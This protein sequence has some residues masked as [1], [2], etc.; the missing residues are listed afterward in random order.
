MNYRQLGR[1]DLRVSELC[2]GT[3]TFGQP[4][5]GCDAQT[6]TDIVDR[7]VDAGGNFFDTAD[8]Y[9]QGEAERMLGRALRGR[10]S[11]VVIATKVGGPTGPGPDDLGLTR[12]HVR[13]A[14]DASLQRLG[15]DYVDLYQ[16]HFFDPRV[17]LEETLVT[18]QDS[19]TAGKVRYIGCSNFSAWQLMKATAIASGHGSVRFESLQPRYSL[20]CRAIEREHLP[21][22]RDQDIGVLPWSPLCRGLLSGKLAGGEPPPGTRLSQERG[23]DRFVTDRNVAIA[24]T[25]AEVAAEL[26]TTSSRLALAWLLAQSGVTAPILGVRTVDQLDD[27]LGAVDVRL[28]PPHAERLDA[29]SRLESVHPYDTH[30]EVAAALKPF[31]S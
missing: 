5:W 20:A 6:A 15:T 10:R 18:L 31:E 1:T 23:S 21:L 19:V 9:Q 28:E 27:N 22:C 25:L 11:D 12:S 14:L 24:G 13:A 16:V 7:F 17:P 3:M 4:E 8:I 26:G 29:V 30:L 2:L